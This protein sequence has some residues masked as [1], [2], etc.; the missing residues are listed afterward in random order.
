MRGGFKLQSYG[1]RGKMKEEDI[2]MNLTD[3]IIIILIGSIMVGIVRKKYC[4]HKNGIPGC[5]CGCSGCVNGTK[6]RKNG[7]ESDK[8]EN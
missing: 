1:L 5:G 2:A 7:D 3:I 8:L 4:D 6:C